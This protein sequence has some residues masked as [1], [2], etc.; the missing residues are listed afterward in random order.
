[1]T[2]PKTEPMT[3]PMTEPTAPP[4]PSPTQTQ[5]VL[6]YLKHRW[7][8]DTR[9]LLAAAGPR[10]E[11]DDLDLDLD[12]VELQK[13]VG[14]DAVAG[15]AAWVLGR[16]EPPAD[17]DPA[18]TA[19]APELSPDPARAFLAL[20]AANVAFRLRSDALLAAL[21]AHTAEGAPPRLAPERLGRLLARA[22]SAREARALVEAA[23]L[24]P[25]EREA[26]LAAAAPPDLPLTGARL[27]AEVGHDVLVELVAELTGLV[28]TTWN[29]QDPGVRRF[30]ALRQRGGFTTLVEEGDAIEPA[31][32]KSLAATKGIGRVAW[33]RFDAEE[34]PDLLL[35]EGT[36]VAFDRAALEARLGAPP[37]D[38]DVAGAL[39]ALGVLDLDPEHPKGPVPLSFAGNLET[40]KKGVRRFALGEP[41]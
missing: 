19:L 3:E 25:A 21:A 6:R 35:F 1:M 12:M 38:E 20:V 37:E 39:R 10:L 7:L 5:L 15:V 33:A 30:M 26:A 40:R 29:D 16:R 11:F 4:A 31:L 23:P 22:R 9:E 14:R 17:D 8:R 24:A 28:P 13:A 32:A 2:E 18:V 41:I 27:H 34:G 36:R